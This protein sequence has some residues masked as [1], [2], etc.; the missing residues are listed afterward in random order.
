MPYCKHCEKYLPARIRIHHC[1]VKGVLTA[2]KD[3]FLIEIE[4]PI[5]Q[6]AHSHMKTIKFIIWVALLMFCG[7]M[8]V[9]AKPTPYWRVRHRSGT[10][11]YTYSKP[12]WG[13]GYG[14]AG[15]YNHQPIKDRNLKRYHFYRHPRTHKRRK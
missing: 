5:K 1:A 7:V 3:K 8:A 2:P 12:N 15:M 6:I 14:C 11:M 4:E 10:E 13:A 9:S